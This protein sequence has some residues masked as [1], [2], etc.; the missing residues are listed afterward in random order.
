VCLLLTGV[1]VKG[2]TIPE[3]VPVEGVV[4]ETKKPPEQR[5]SRRK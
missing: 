5:P 4:P 3:V 1:E 2:S